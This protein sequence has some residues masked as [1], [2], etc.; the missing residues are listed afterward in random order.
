MPNL[1]DVVREAALEKKAEDVTTIEL[2]GRTVVADQ[3]VICSGRSNVQNRAIADGIEEAAAAAGYKAGRTEGYADGNWILIDLGT[4]I[5][6]I[7]TPDQRAFYNL[8]RL[9]GGASP[10]AKESG[11]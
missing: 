2:A 9:W 5:V 3:F 7:F 1:A 8:E 6:H 10:A 11:T 4:V